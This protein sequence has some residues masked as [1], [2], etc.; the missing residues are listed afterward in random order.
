[1]SGWWNFI[2]YVLGIGNMM[3]WFDLRWI[4]SLF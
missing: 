1:M 3:W 4:W 2:G